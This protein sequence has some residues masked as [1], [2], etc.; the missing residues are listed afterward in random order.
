MHRNRTVVSFRLFRKNLGN[1]RERFGQIVYPPPGI[2]IARTPM[3]FH[4]KYFVY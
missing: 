1:M 3:G 2:I 4:S